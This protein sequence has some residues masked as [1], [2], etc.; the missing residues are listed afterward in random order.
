MLY[1]LLHYPV[2]V[3]Y[4]QQTNELEGIVT[5]KYHENSSIETMDPYYQKEGAKFFSVTGILV[6]QRENML[7]KGIGSNL[8]SA[9]ILGIQQ[10]AQNH[11][12]EGLELN[13]VIDCTNLPSL[14]AL[15]NGTENLQA[16]GLVGKNKEL[17]AILDA[18]YVVRDEKH[19]LVEAPTYVLKI[20]LEP[21]DIRKENWNSEERLK[22]KN[23][24]SYNVDSNKNQHQNYEMLLDTILKEI[25]KDENCVATQME[26]VGT[27]TVTYICVENKKIYMRNMVLERNE[28]QN[29]GKKR[30]PRNDVSQF[31]G[32]MPDISKNIQEDGERDDR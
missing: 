7:N 27:G 8:Y 3:A 23:V 9:S 30:T 5:I 26:D 15:I 19:H 10:Y 20:N 25:K 21:K 13:V 16:R 18:I 22:N 28:A 4:D 1:N 31:V 2:L 32:P 11:E 24:F 12:G 6:K 17:E 29:I 14:Y